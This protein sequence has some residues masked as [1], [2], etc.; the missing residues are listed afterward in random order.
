MV[1]IT[2]SLNVLKSND[3]KFI[4]HYLCLSNFEIFSNEVFSTSLFFFGLRSQICKNRPKNKQY[5]SNLEQI[6]FPFFNSFLPYEFDRS[7]LKFSFFI[8]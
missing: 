8:C 7:I 1:D 4:E 2:T 5:F 6:L 3:R